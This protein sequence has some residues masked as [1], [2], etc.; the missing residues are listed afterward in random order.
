MPLFW[1]GLG[2][3]G[4]ETTTVLKILAELTQFPW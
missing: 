2:L 1:H 4:S 3:H